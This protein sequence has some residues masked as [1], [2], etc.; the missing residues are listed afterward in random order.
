MFYNFGQKVV[1]KFTKL[2]KIGF[3]IEWFTADFSRFSSANVKK[4]FSGGRLGT[5]YQI[6]AFQRF[7]KNFLI[8]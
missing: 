7:F 8:S 5:R 1:D 3:S 2:T 4:C 6:Q